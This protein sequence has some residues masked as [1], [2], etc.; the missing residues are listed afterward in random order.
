MESMYDD[1]RS[2]CKETIDENLSTNELLNIKSF[3]TKYKIKLYASRGLKFYKYFSPSPF[4]MDYFEDDTLS[5]SNPK[6]FNDVFEGMVLSTD[7]ELK[8]TRD[9]IEKVCK[10]VSISCFSETWD[11]VLM[12]SHYADSF[13]GYCLEYDISLAEDVRH[14]YYEHFF[15]VLYQSKPVKLAQMRQLSEGIDKVISARSNNKENFT[16]VDDIISY[17]IHKAD[18]WEYE[19]EW[20]YIIPVSDFSVFQNP[21][22]GFDFHRMKNFD[23]VTGVYL[24]ANI[25]EA[26]RY[27]LISIVKEKNKKRIGTSKPPVTIY[28]TRIDP[29]S[30]RLVN[31]VKSV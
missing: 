13:K 23:C 26:T 21:D 10:S 15:P 30:Y 24:G 7:L 16:K 5:F 22:H 9:I 20:R 18:I 3:R 17:F 6:R 8:E 31:E 4:Y 12:F 29:N 19:K 28:Q 1:L 14:D 25:S 11:N 2:L 27:R